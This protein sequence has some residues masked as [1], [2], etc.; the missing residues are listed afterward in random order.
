MQERLAPEPVVEKPA[1]QVQVAAPLALVL[2]DGQPEQKL[3]WATLYEP[4]LQAAGHNVGQTA[5]R[6]LVRDGHVCKCRVA[7]RI[8]AYA[9]MWCRAGCR[10]PQCTLCFHSTVK[11]SSH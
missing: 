6:A 10:Y 11:S 3:A 1:L 8:A 5:K 2:D 9:G 4:A 7:A